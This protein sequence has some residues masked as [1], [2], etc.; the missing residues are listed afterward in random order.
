M[1][2]LMDMIKYDWNTL[3]NRMEYEIIRKYT[4]IG[5][6][7]SQLFTRKMVKLY[8]AISQKFIL[9]KFINIIFYKLFYNL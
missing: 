3:K 9:Y 8:Y 4:C 7:Y 6:F 1:R 5:A 2:E